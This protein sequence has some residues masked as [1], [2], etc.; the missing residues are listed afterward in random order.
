MQRG[1]CR[2][3]AGQ[4]N[5]IGLG[6]RHFGVGNW[7]AQQFCE[8]EL[9]AG[10]AK[11]VRCLLFAKTE[12]HQTFFTYASSQASKV[13]IAGDQT[14]TIETAGVKQVHRIDDERAIGCIF[15]RGVCKLLYWF[16][17]VF[18]EYFFQDELLEEVKSP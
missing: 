14:E 18:L 13:T 2:F 17:G 7:R 15:P 5:R 6:G 8:D 11:S 16:D 3:G 12:N 9:V 1:G 4:K 10:I